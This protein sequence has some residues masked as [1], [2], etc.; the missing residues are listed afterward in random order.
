MAALLARTQVIRAIL[1]TTAGLDIDRFLIRA[2]LK[3]RLGADITLYTKKGIAS[4]STV[5]LSIE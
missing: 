5:N 1:A 3:Q 2:S 4:S